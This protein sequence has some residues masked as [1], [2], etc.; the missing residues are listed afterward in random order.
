LI[1]I[2]Q[3]AKY[4]NPEGSIIVT[5]AYRKSSGELSKTEHLIYYILFRFEIPP[6]L[7]RRK[8]T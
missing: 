7:V 5:V 3:L 8:T 4:E 1:G 2:I 6:C